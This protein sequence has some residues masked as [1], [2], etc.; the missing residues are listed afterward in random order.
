V[1]GRADHRHAPGW[2]DRYRNHVLGHRLA[3]AY[4]CIEAFGRDVRQR[5]ITDRLNE[6]VRILRQPVAQDRPKNRAG[7]MFAGGEPNRADRLVGR[8]PRQASAVSMS[9]RFGI[10][11]LDRRSPAS[12]GATL[13]VVR[14]S[15]RRRAAPPARM[16][17]LSADCDTPSWAAARVKLRSRATTKKGR[18]EKTYGRS[19]GRG[20][21]SIQE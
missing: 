5:G 3:K 2:S 21:T 20:A 12:V 4:A 17:W 13:R 16:V 19:V 6:E 7:S 8:L 15:R 9:W 14:V 1:I 10:S 11:A 18:R